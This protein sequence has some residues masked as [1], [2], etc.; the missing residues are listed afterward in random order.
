MTPLMQNTIEQPN[1]TSAGSSLVLV[2]LSI[3]LMSRERDEDRKTALAG[4]CIFFSQT[5][6]AMTWTV[7]ATFL[8]R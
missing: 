1:A 7:L 4:A 6:E 3:Y 8:V 5:M 2:R